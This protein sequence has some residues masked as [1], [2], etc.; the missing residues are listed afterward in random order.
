MAIAATTIPG[1]TAIEV[2]RMVDTQVAPLNLVTGARWRRPT[3]IAMDR[4]IAVDHRAASRRVNLKVVCLRGVSLR[5]V[6][7]M[8][9]LPS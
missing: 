4:Q 2:V 8:G 1:T 3:D 5:G 7:A 9:A 6:S